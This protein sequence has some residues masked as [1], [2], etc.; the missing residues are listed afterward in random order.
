MRNT[1]GERKELQQLDA[2]TAWKTLGVMQCITGDESSELE[3]LLEKINTWSNN[4]WTSWLKHEEARC[5]V[6][7]T[8][9]KTISYPLPATA[10]TPTQYAKTSSAF[11]KTALPKT[12][13]VLSA[14]RQVVFAPTS[15]MGFGFEDYDML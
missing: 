10:F 2:S 1:D 14:S 15:I 12:G 4:I 6:S 8:I 9:G 11:L 7:A 3:Y 5:A 13:I